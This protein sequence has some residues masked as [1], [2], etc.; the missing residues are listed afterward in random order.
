MKFSF[1]ILHYMAVDDTIEC[2]D[3]IINNLHNDIEIIVDDNNSPDNSF[4]ILKKKYGVN[5]K[6]HLL[7]NEENIG[8]AKG[9][10]IGFMYAK[11]KLNPDFIIIINNDTIIEQKDFCDKIES[12]YKK[13]RFDIAGPNI[14]SLKDTLNQ[15]P[16]PYILNNKSKIKKRIIKYKILKLCALCNFDLIIH[17]LLSI[18]KIKKNDNSNNDYKLHGS[19]LMFSKDYINKY[20]GLYEKTFMYGEEDILKYIS[21]RDNLK[22]IYLKNIKII[23]KEDSSTDKVFS[24]KRRKRIF[25]YKWNI[26]SLEILYDLMENDN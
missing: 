6:I 21:I 22:M 1:V 20:N 18:F 15:N 5:K 12:N 23:H 16:I 11:T 25:Y 26:N 17:K 24:N 9:N 14:V 2:V 10:N 7:K 4:N 19:A 13:N 3:S 8:F